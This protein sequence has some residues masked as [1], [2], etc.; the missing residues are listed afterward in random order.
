MYLIDTNVIGEIRKRRQANT[1]VV[2]FFVRVREEDSALY[3]SAI[4]IGELR[5]GVELVRYRGDQR[6]A[7]RLERWLDEIM[8]NFADHILEFGVMES[9][10]WGTLRVPHPERPID[11]QVAA[12]ALSYGLTLVTR[13]TKAFAGT[14]LELLNPFKEQRRS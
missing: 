14:G 7:R 5:R 9:Q 3:L 1:G 13:N 6:Q 2:R 10:I 11:K 4:S 12:T 8:E